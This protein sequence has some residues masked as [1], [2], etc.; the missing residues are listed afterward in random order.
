MRL[1]AMLDDLEELND[2]L[3]AQKPKYCKFDGRCFSCSLYSEDTGRDCKKNPVP[4]RLQSIIKNG[5]GGR[6]HTF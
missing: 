2:I 4:L 3:Q 6:W 5:G 1:D